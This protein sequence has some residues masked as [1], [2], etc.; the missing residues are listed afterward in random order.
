MRKLQIISIYAAFIP[1]CELAHNSEDEG[2]TKRR[3]RFSHKKCEHT[4]VWAAFFNCN[5]EEGPALREV[6]SKYLKKMH[7]RKRN[8]KYL[9][10]G[11]ITSICGSFRLHNGNLFIIVQAE[12]QRKRCNRF[13]KYFEQNRVPAKHM[14]LWEEEERRQP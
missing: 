12:R 9:Q 5:F 7:I 2:G 13:C 1:L 10:K 4:E 8:E 14:V 3:S 6:P 11:Q